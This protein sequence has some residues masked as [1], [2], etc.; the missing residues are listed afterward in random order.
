MS[1]G[2][3]EGEPSHCVLCDK[4]FNIPQSFKAHLETHK[5]E[6]PYLCEFCDKTF[7][8]KEHINRH[9][10]MH[11]NGNPFSCEFCDKSFPVKRP[12]MLHLETH[13]SAKPYLCNKCGMV[14][15]TKIEL[16]NHDIE[17]DENF[18]KSLTH[19]G[20]TSKE[21]PPELSSFSCDK[22]DKEFVDYLNLKKHQRTHTGYNIISCNVCGKSFTTKGY[23]KT[24]MTIHKG[25]KAY[26]CDICG[27]ANRTKLLL[28]S[29]KRVHSREASTLNEKVL[30]PNTMPIISLNV[31]PNILQF[32]C[33]YCR[34]Q[35]SEKHD[36]EKHE[37]LHQA[38]H[39][40]NGF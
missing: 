39:I 2:N 25:D 34:E 12:L 29:H 14:F 8:T 13:K 15:D 38:V 18:E 27:K 24:H 36:L 35:F 30:Q 16:G 1:L 11:T 23:L 26:K 22:C 37:K 32:S 21:I 6:R 9:I 31:T 33:G 20:Q 4:S 7:K 28:S 10:Q 5:E 3:N 40:S 17:H 19:E